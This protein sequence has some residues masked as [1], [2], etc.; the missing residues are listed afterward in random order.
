MDE[1]D[2]LVVGGMFGRG[3][4]AANRNN[5]AS[6][7]LCAVAKPAAEGGKPTEFHTFCRVT[8]YEY[9]YIYIYIY[10]WFCI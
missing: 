9:I 8:I 3:H 7:F 6:H 4:R 10:S 1:L 2:I 5:L